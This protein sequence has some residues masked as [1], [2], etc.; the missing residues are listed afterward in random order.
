MHSQEILPMLRDVGAIITNSHLVLTSGR[1]TSAYVNKDALYVH[2]QATSACCQLIAD[3][4]AARQIDAVVGPALGGILL[5]QWVAYHLNTRRTVGETLALYAEK[6]GNGTEKR[7]FFSRGY[8]SLVAHRH[9]LVVEDVL[10]TGGSARKVV[11]LVRSQGG[12]VVGLSALCNRGDV[13]PEDV[14]GV[15]IS[16]LAQVSFTS[17]A[18]EQCP[19]CQQGVPI[20]TEVGKGRAFLAGQGK[21]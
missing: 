17:W 16:A 18:A 19:L 3:H 1:H 20:N 9:V 6:E 8:G 15:P 5:A 10:V 2:P 14:G 13:Q 7:L 11:E 4:Y 21:V 12:H